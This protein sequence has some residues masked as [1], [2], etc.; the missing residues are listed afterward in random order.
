MGYL[1]DTRI[2][3][4]TE[5]GGYSFYDEPSVD[6]LED[7]GEIVRRFTY[8]KQPNAGFVGFHCCKKSAVWECTKGYVDKVQDEEKLP[9]Q[10]RYIVCYYKYENGDLLHMVD[11]DIT[12]SEI[13][14][15]VISQKYTEGADYYLLSA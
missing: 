1:M 14:A 7:F 11:W 4:K 13:I 10:E 3:Y 8:D 15:N 9:D 5:D 6:E 2:I 12:K